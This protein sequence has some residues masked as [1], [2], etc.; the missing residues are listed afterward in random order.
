M[1][2]HGRGRTVV[3]IGV[4]GA[5]LVGT[6]LLVYV[7]RREDPQ[8]TAGAMQFYYIPIILA[9]FF[10]GDI[11]AILVALL[12]GLVC[13]HLQDPSVSNPELQIIT[14]TLFFFIIGIFASRASF[15]LHRRAE[16][17]ETLY[18]VAHT[19]SSSLE[20]DQVL[21]RIVSGAVR[22]MDAKG[23]TI[24]LLDESQERLDL[25]AHAGLSDEYLRK[26]LVRL[27][28]SPLDRQVLNGGHVAILNAQNDPAWQYPDAAAQEGLT[29]VL[30][31]PLKTANGNK[32]VIRIY[33][34]RPRRFARAEIAL[35]TAFANQAAVAIE[36]AELYADI[37]RN[38]YETVRALTRAIEA[39]DPA[40]L[41]HSER[42]T[43]M[44]VGLAKTMGYSAE[45]REVIRFGAILHDIGKIGVAEEV[46]EHAREADA[47]D[48]MFLRMHPLIGK[49]ILDPVEFLKPAVDVVMYHHE[50]WDGSGYPEGRKGEEIPAY[51]RLV[52]PL[53]EYDRLVSPSDGRPAMAPEHAFEEI[54]SGAGTKWDPRVIAALVRMHQLGGTVL[55]SAAGHEGAGTGG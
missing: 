35:L 44:A 37:K 13:T 39:K 14:R 47:T 24:R 30:S 27:A 18:E 32:G 53:N 38:Y 54:V 3:M 36:N 31:I 45:E 8:A 49:S 20:L 28:E 15:A 51:A 12:A 42:V 17:F 1:T 26:G 7:A 46:L 22:V 5:L 40:T 55:A 50:K 33:A 11:G 52:A 25:A 29:S 9:G 10:L 34:R 48:E 21:N 19:I 41:G 2:Q 6:S 4:I 43:D 23:C 16:E